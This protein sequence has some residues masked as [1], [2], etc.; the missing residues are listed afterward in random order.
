MILVRPLIIILAVMMALLLLFAGAAHDN[1]PY[2][3][4]HSAAM[5]DYVLSAIMFVSV[6][7]ELLGAR[8]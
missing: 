5:F 7:I 6:A 8:R 1:D 2:G 4:D 3:P